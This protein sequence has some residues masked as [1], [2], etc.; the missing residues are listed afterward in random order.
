MEIELAI[1][2]TP[3]ESEHKAANEKLNHRLSHTFR[4]SDLQVAALTDR[5]GSCASLFKVR[6]YDTLVRVLHTV[7]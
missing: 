1:G 4:R 6:P 2:S 5:I 3:L 7:L